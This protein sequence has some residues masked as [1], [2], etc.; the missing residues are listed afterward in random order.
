[1]T[2][3][4]LT[5]ILAVLAAVPVLAQECPA[6]FDC[7]GVDVHKPLQQFELVS[8]S[9][10]I[11][12]TP[13]KV[14]LLHPVLKHLSPGQHVSFTLTVRWQGTPNPCSTGHGC[15][16]LVGMRYRDEQFFSAWSS[17]T[18]TADPNPLMTLDLP[19][20]ADDHAPRGCN[21]VFVLISD[22]VTHPNEVGRALFSLNVPVAIHADHCPER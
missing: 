18:F 8:G 16:A 15:I 17:F 13:G 2:T 1:M 7:A 4:V 10:Q 20:Q 22:R 6:G 21:D 19:S 14:D 12:H 5:A 11:G 9:A 3:K